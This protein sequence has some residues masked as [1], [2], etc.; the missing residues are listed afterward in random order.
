PLQ[1]TFSEGRRDF[2]T[3]QGKSF[4]YN[5]TMYGYPEPDTFIIHKSSQE[6]TNIIMTRL[7]MEAPYV[8]VELRIINITFTDFDQY[9]LIIFLYGSKCLTF[10][11]SIS[12]DKDITTDVAAIIGGCIGACVVMINIIAVVYVNK[13]YEINLICKKKS[14]DESN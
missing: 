10:Q 4:L 1:F 12:E 11:F 5:V 13:K 3:K 7:P 8:T 2:T 6:S 9:S 14:S